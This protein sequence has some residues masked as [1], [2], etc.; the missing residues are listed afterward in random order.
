MNKLSESDRQVKQKPEVGKRFNPKAKSS[1]FPLYLNTPLGLIFHKDKEGNRLSGNHIR[2]WQV[3][4]WFSKKGRCD[5]SL[6]QIAAAT[7]VTKRQASNLIAKL[8]VEGFLQRESP[9]KAEYFRRATTKYYFLWHE[10][11]NVNDSRQIWKSLTREIYFP[12]EKKSTREIQFPSTREKIDTSLGKSISPSKL[13]I[14]KE[15][16]TT[17]TEQS[18]GNQEPNTDDGQGSSS[19]F[20]FS[21]KESTALPTDV[22]EYIELK[23]THMANNGG[24]KNSRA[25]YKAQLVKLYWNGQLNYVDEL[26]ELKAKREPMTRA[27]GN[28]LTNYGDDWERERL[29]TERKIQQQR[30]H[31][32]ELKREMEAL[33]QAFEKAHMRDVYFARSIFSDDYTKGLKKEAFERVLGVQLHKQMMDEACSW[34][35]YAEQ[36]KIYGKTQPYCGDCTHLT[37]YLCNVD[38]KHRLPEQGVCEDFEQR[39]CADCNHFN[40]IEGCEMD[41]AHAKAKDNGCTEFDNVPF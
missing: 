8:I 19:N 16:E 7:D 5:L 11:F 24:F 39:H 25:A 15:E 14:K 20:S 33:Q 40:E 4:V 34:E 18:A 28:D 13:D 9:S 23:L 32:E 27:Q 12:S 35:T 1:S 3:M 37:E 22:A 36:K 26:Q 2:V 21:G 38:H 31:E 29:A 10:A 17:T 6:E 30:E 41:G